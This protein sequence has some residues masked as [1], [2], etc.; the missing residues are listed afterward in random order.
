TGESAADYLRWLEKE[1]LKEL[2]DGEH[3]EENAALL[4]RRS[5]AQVSED[6]RLVL[7]IAGCLAFAP[8]S[9]SPAAAVLVGDERRVRKA[10]GELVNYGLLEKAG[11]RWQVSHALVHT[12]AREELALSTDAL[13]RLAG[14]YIVF[15]GTASKEGV[16]GYTRLDAERTHCLRLIESCLDGGLWEDVQRLVEVMLEY[17]DRQGYWMELLTAVGM[18]LVAAQHAGDRKGEQWSLNSLGYICWKR[19]ELEQA[20]VWY[21]QSLPI[22]RELGDL[23]GKG[24]IL[25]NMAL[26]YNQQSKYKLALDQY[27]QSLSIKREIGDRKG[28][29]TT[30]NNIGEL[31]RVQG[32]YEQ[33][34]QYY[35]QSLPIHKE[36]GNK[37]LEG[38]TLNNIATIY[39]TQY[40]RTKAVEYH[41]Q[42]LIIHCELGDRVGEVG[43]HWN[44]ALAYEDLGDLVEAEE[45]FSLAVQIAKQ[46]NHPLLEKLSNRLALVQAI[47]KRKWWSWLYKNGMIL[48]NWLRAKR[49]RA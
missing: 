20:L 19:G 37:L 41:K 49:Q 12:Y 47:L 7:G 5:M 30:L 16:Q 40:K 23:Q 18:H 39:T 38:A 27:Q 45:H 31:Y 48:S 6:A 42:A 33:A 15:C 43:V 10:L 1:P 29:G 17:F 28:E 44:I 2:G 21:N 14:W 8:M 13:K 11:E 32:D 24:I 25:N 26:I 9:G 36:V 35:K 4:L 34:L 3:Q 22:C 46:I